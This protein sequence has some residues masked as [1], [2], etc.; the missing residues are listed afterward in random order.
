MD[1]ADPLKDAW[2]VRRAVLGDAYVD[3][4]AGDP[5]PVA[6][7]FQ[8]YIT[9]MV[10]G[11]WARGGALTPRDRSLL[12]LA[13]TATLGR[14]EEFRTH[15]AAAPRAGVTQKELDE[16]SFQIAAY[17][18]APAGVAARRGLAETEEARNAARHGAPDG[19]RGGD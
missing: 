8:D 14:M 4:A 2:A 11:V 1:Q 7:A 6:G 12:V 9:E 19:A 15:A 3:A 16:L 5:R 18:G 13:M 17:C 10:W